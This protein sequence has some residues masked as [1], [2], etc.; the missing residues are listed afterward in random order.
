MMK[1]IYTL[2]ILLLIPACVS[3]VYFD[4]LKITPKTINFLYNSNGEIIKSSPFPPSLHALF[5]VDSGSKNMLFEVLSGY[6]I[7]LFLIIIIA[8][9]SMLISIFIGK[10]GRA[11]C[12]ERVYR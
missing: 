7:T 9:L 3:I 5:G 8:S 2:L 10:I 6:R 4:I 12:R 1:R 11:S